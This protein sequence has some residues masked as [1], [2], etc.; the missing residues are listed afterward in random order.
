MEH[1]RPTDTAP[2][3]HVTFMDWWLRNR[4]DHDASV[5][6]DIERSCTSK[7]SYESEEAARAVAA[8]NGMADVLFTYHCRYCDGWHLTRQR[9]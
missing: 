3:A 5:D 7:D 2:G 1:H 8:M 6:R 9:T 4:G